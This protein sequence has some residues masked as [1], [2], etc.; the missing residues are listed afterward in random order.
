MD[1]LEQ[2]V[3]FW[4][5]E[6]LTRELLNRNPRFLT[7]LILQW[8]PFSIQ[9]FTIR[10]LLGSIWTKARSS[11]AEPRLTLSGRDA[12][13]RNLWSLKDR[14]A[15]LHKASKFLSKYF[16]ELE[17]SKC[18][19][20]ISHQQII[21]QP[22]LKTL[23]EMNNDSLDFLRWNLKE[24]LK[25]FANVLLYVAHRD[26]LSSI[27][28][29]IF[30]FNFALGPRGITKHIEEDEECRS[31]TVEQRTRLKLDTRRWEKQIYRQGTILSAMEGFTSLVEQTFAGI[32]GFVDDIFEYLTR[33]NE[34]KQR[35]KPP[36]KSSPKSSD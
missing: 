14:A 22:F 2:E 17:S 1:S 15:S 6:K 19:F 20:D 27:W 34:F 23:E 35:N 36:R 31:S 26:C 9:L 13:L 33:P 21:L 7:W 5:A 8:T 28:I 10:Q 29:W 11:D 25:R 16:L 12:L 32:E 3:Q 24:I 4:N 18:D 30:N